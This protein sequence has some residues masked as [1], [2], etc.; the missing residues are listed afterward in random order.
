[1]PSTRIFIVI[2]PIAPAGEVLMRVVA[3]TPATGGLYRLDQLIAAGARRLAVVDGHGLLRGLVC[4]KRR[5]T[6]FCSD[7]DVRARAMALDA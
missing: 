7:L 3:S 5:R 4:L 1:M 6:G 2:D